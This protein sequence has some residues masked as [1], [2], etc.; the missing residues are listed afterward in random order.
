MYSVCNITIKPLNHMRKVKDKKIFIFTCRFSFLALS[1]I[2]NA[3]HLGLSPH[4][5]QLLRFHSSNLT[6]SAR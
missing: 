3:L 6:D 5:C 2:D 4:F 1:V